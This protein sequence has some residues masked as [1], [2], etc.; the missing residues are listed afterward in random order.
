MPKRL[1]VLLG[2]LVIA[3]L[4]LAPLASAATPTWGSIHTIADGGR[5]SAGAALFTTKSSTTRYLHATWRKGAGEVRFA[6]STNGGTTWSSSLLLANPGFLLGEP[7]ISA[8]GSDVWVSWVRR[9]VDEDTGTFGYAVLVR[10]NR[11]HGAASAWSSAIRLTS[12]TGNVRGANIA[13]TDG[14]KAIYVV[15]SDLRNDVT[16][17]ASSHNG[18]KTW[19]VTTVGEGF[20]VD[21]EDV[22]TTLP[23]VAASGD[24]VLV[25]W[26]AEGNVATAR[27][28]TDGG[29]HWSDEAI[30]GEGLSTAAAK[31]GRMAIGGRAEIGP[32]VR[33]WTNGTWGD[34][35]E[36]PEVMLGGNVA[37][38][39][40]LDIRLNTDHR[41]GAVYSAQVDV[42]EETADTWEEVTWFTSPD[43]G[44]TWSS[45]SRVSRAGSETAA[46]NA[47]RPTAVWLE[48]GKLWIMWLQEKPTAAG[49]YFLAIRE[50]S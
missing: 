27:T 29:E 37:S 24:N 23:V 30:V 47:D 46:F 50:R 1:P 32:W 3:A 25:G 21:F 26:L 40:E 7:A 11:S 8:A 5:P 39:V 14:G 49:T 4:A 16:R 19:A 31:G 38:A 12:M 43:D 42:D 6:R 13:V 41:I 17:L 33:V 36:I 2:T 35:S 20:D 9:Y 45:P 28:S 18:G 15:W 34:L 10:H 22:P 44:D 48:N